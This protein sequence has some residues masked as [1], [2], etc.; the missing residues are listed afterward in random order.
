LIASWGA[1]AAFA[2]KKRLIAT[3]S[4]STTLPCG[5]MRSACLAARSR[6]TNENRLLDETALSREI[7]E[8]RLLIDRMAPQLV[9]TPRG[10]P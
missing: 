1:R 5:F 7:A 10:S 3:V 4:I 6:T 8:M 2:S 9:I